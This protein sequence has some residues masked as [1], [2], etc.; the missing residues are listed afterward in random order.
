MIGKNISRIRNSRGLTI[1]ELA[2]RSKIS[3]SY[4]SNIERD[5]NKNPSIEVIN[6]IARVLG[7]DVKALLVTDSK[8]EVKQMPDKEWLKLI[9]ELKESGIDRENL[10]EYRVLIDFIKWKNQ[11]DTK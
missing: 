2:E 9:H 10:K 3:K 6:K 11:I 7:V 4:L 5:L 8:E 1:S